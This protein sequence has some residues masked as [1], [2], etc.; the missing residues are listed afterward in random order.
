MTPCGRPVHGW[1]PAWRRVCYIQYGHGWVGGL[2]ILFCL[3]YDTGRISRSTVGL[4]WTPLSIASAHNAP[5]LCAL[6]AP[7]SHFTTPLDTPCHTPLHISILCRCGP[8][9]RL[10][11]QDQKTHIASHQR[12][13]SRR[14]RRSKV[15]SRIRQMYG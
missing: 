4:P 5:P 1:P 13:E 12:G 2:E 14:A 6:R 10:H 11:V 15:G 7:F 8:H 9:E 3:I